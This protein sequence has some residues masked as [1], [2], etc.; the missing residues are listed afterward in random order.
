M[1]GENSLQKCRA[2]ITHG[3]KDTE[4]IGITVAILD[5]LCTH[6]WDY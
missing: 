1:R 5:T 3:F 2:L 6:S 4:V